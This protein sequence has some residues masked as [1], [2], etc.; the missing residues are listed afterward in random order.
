MLD[1]LLAT[2]PGPWSASGTPF[3]DAHLI[4]TGPEIWQPM[5]SEIICFVMVLVSL[6]FPSGLCLK[7][8]TD[9]ILGLPM[10]LLLDIV[11]CAPSVVSQNQ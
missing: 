2:G 7:S 1:Y 3:A 10:V 4:G 11:P 9:D 6:P 8:M 5:N